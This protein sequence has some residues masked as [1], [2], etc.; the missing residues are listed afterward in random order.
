[1]KTA[2]QMICWRKDFFRDTSL[3]AAISPAPKE[4]PYLTMALLYMLSM[5]DL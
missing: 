2:K 3:R 5:I 1:M 4:I